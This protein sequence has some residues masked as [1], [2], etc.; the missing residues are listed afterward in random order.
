MQDLSAFGKRKEML[1]IEFVE[2]HEVDAFM[3]SLF[4]LGSHNNLV[5]DLVF[6]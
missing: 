2:G 1:L 4:F 6:F 5:S 3:Y